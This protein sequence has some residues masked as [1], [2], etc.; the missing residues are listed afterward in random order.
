MKPGISTHALDICYLANLVI[1]S[2]TVKNFMT[3]KISFNQIFVI[4]S[5]AFQYDLAN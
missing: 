4:Q 3:L 1:N 2:L 5:M